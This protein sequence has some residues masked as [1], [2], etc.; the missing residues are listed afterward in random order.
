MLK[1]GF[2]NS[3]ESVCGPEGTPGYVVLECFQTQQVRRLF[4]LGIQG[5]LLGH[6]LR[7][8][9]MWKLLDAITSEVSD[10]ARND[11]LTALNEARDR[12]PRLDRQ[13]LQN[14][15]DDRDNDDDGRVSGTETNTSGTYR[16]GYFGISRG[17]KYSRKALS[18]WDST[19]TQEKTLSRLIPSLGNKRKGLRQLGLLSKEGKRWLFGSPLVTI[20]L[21]VGLK[22]LV[23]N[24][25][26]T[27]QTSSSCSLG[28]DVRKS[29]YF[30]PPY[31]LI[32]SKDEAIKPPTFWP[33]NSCVLSKE[34]IKEREQFLSSSIRGASSL[35]EGLK[36]AEH[37]ELPQVMSSS[38]ESLRE[39]GSFEISRVTSLLRGELR[40]AAPFETHH[41]RH[42]PGESKEL[43]DLKT[44]QVEPTAGTAKN[45]KTNNSKTDATLLC[46][47]VYTSDDDG[48]TADSRSPR[49]FI[50]P[51][52]GKLFAAG[53]NLRT[54]QRTHSGEKPY[55]CEFCQQPFSTVSNLK[56]HVRTHTKEKPYLC[57]QCHVRFA[58]SSNLKVHYRMHT[59][60]RP[61][62]CNQ[63][64]RE[65]TEVDKENVGARLLY[66]L[67]KADWEKL[68]RE[69]ILPQPLS[70]GDNINL[71]AKEL[72]WVSQAAMRKAIPIMKEVTRCIAAG[73]IRSP[74]VIL[75]LKKPE[76]GITTCQEELARLLKDV[77]LPDDNPEEGDE[78]NERDRQ[79]M[80]M[81]YNNDRGEATPEHVTLDCI[82]TE[83][84]RVELLMPIQANAIYH[85]LRAVYL[86]TYLNEI[87]DRVSKVE[88]DR[89]MDKLKE[90]RRQR[91]NQ[92]L[93]QNRLKETTEEESSSRGKASTDEMSEVVPYSKSP[94]RLETSVMLGWSY[95][96]LQGCRLATVGSRG[97]YKCHLLVHTGEKKF[98]C[99]VCGKQFAS[100][101]NLKI[102]LRGHTGYKPYHCGLCKQE[103]ATKSNLNTHVK[104]QSC[105][106]TF[107][108][109]K[110]GVEFVQYS[111]MRAHLATHQP[112]A[113]LSANLKHILWDGGREGERCGV[114][115][116]QTEVSLRANKN[117]W[118][119]ETV[120]GANY[121]TG[122]IKQK[123]KLLMGHIRGLNSDK[124]TYL[125]KERTPLRACVPQL[126]KHCSSLE[127]DC[128]CPIAE[129]TF[130][131]TPA[132]A[133]P[134]FSWAAS[135][136][137]LTFSFAPSTALPTLSLAASPVSGNKCSHY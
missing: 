13:E 67:K 130:S 11:Y 94:A 108:C 95:R 57:D 46:E 112:L 107:V 8:P 2:I 14:R 45:R 81:A 15:T 116:Q 82:F 110:C 26:L 43:H 5:R 37:F 85:I 103:F 89:H 21:R 44:L 33:P 127:S 17:L 101:S 69:L 4:Q 123:R 56:T 126:G 87:A 3:S 86:W 62:Q 47:V 106:K 77:L 133:S 50:C 40:E 38:R 41:A 97:N 109:K 79:D 9:V 93:R 35:R 98:K 65:F 128:T 134:I 58:T 102:H 23:M 132:A 70:Q 71:K 124:A 117:R 36:E 55:K 114:A 80:K 16:S 78:E 64:G 12:R 73:K 39:D 104:S 136:I 32:G 18:R 74:A 83:G 121:Q 59:G 54:H 22:M 24:I 91:K 63:C 111:S 60:E 122:L 52:C 96:E 19:R 49:R 28:K 92:D 10:K 29:P 105:T 113:L 119:T 115:S 30:W 34:G 42:P 90:R 48:K 129:L 66:N 100:S 68:R 137:S 25:Y 72:M 51:T 88:R 75:T 6:I 118:I 99:L 20:G 27:Y 76:G 125:L 120:D 7:D 53:G 131:L 31:P 135:A 61:Y 1:R 84:E